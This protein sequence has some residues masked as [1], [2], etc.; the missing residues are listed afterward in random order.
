MA[1]PLEEKSCGSISPLERGLQ[2]TWK[3][4]TKREA[5]TGLEE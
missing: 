1:V 5:L 4:L 2:E 3:G